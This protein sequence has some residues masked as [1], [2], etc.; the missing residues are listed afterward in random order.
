MPISGDELDHNPSDE[1]SSTMSKAELR[2]VACYINF[3]RS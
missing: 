3:I 2:K 1:P